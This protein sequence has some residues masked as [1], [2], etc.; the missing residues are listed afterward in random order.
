M[1]AN[2][3]TNPVRSNW[4]QVARPVV[5]PR[6]RLFCFSYAGGNA[7]T[8][9]EWHKRLPE[10]VEVCSIQLPGRGSRFKEKAFTDLDS[11]LT[12][13]VAEIAPYTETSY[14]FFGHSMGAQVAFE[15][16]R[17]LRDKGLEQP[18]C[19]I[20]SGRRAPQRSKKSKP[21]YSLPEAE[22]RD[23]IRR[24][25]GTPEEALNNP[26]LMDLV[27]PILRADFQLIETWVYQPSDPID[28]PVLALG[29]VKDKQVT[30]D[31]LEDWKKVTKGPFCLELFSGDHF[32]I[33]QA[34]D[35]LLNTVNQAIETVLGRADGVLANRKTS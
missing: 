4:F 22:F 31:D 10:D 30:M 12:S 28:V 6:L 13:L 9:R 29:G 20:V 17:K 26:E 11:L 3:S 35:T 21:I 19:L 23:E 7:S 32:F 18:K 2:H 33:N 1:M 5:S 25:N 27:S 15:L 16:A 34:T 14:A 24:L 8:Y